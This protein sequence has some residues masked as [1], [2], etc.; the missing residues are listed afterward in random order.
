MHTDVLTNCL[1]SLGLSRNSTPQTISKL[2]EEEQH[3]DDDKVS[4]T[5]FI[6]N[7]PD[8]ERSDNGDNNET[9][10]QTKKKVPS[11]TESLAVLCHP[12]YSLVDAYPTLCQVY[13]VANYLCDRGVFIL[14]TQ[15]G[16]DSYSF[17]ND[18]GD[19]NLCLQW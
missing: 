9:E 3:H 5:K 15:E 1:I 13:D 4:R 17:V 11:F 8:S 10:K 6:Q 2:D 19:L 14:S 16:E 7:G 18:S 12:D